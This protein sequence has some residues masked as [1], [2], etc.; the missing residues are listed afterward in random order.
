MK[1][2]YYLITNN[3]KFGK[4]NDKININTFPQIFIS[5]ELNVCHSELSELSLNA[6]LFK[7]ISC[8][9]L[10]L[11]YNN[12]LFCFLFFFFDVF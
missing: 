11:N 3:H 4:V 1:Y 7:L 2:N 5:D 8:Q 10:V 9:L 6:T 12:I